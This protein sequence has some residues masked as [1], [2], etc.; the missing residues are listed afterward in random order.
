M[1][2]ARYGDGAVARSS[3]DARSF[4][5]I[6]DA[7]LGRLAAGAVPA[8]PLDE[9]ALVV[10]PEATFYRPPRGRFEDLRSRKAA[11]SLLL[12][13]VDDHQSGD[14]ARGLTIAELYDVGWAGERA[15]DEAAANR[16]HVNLAALR[17]RGLK[18]FLV[19]KGERYALDD[20]LRIL[21]IVSDWPG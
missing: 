7:A 20:K 15:T 9:D 13:L 5:R 19:L 12:A 17:K 3:D 14:R 11:R 21:R 16:V 10:G 2:R 8:V 4:L 6:L 18:A 1:K